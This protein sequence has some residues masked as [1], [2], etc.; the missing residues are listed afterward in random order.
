MEESKERNPKIPPTSLAL[1]ISSLA[2][3]AFDHFS[4]LCFG[5]F[6]RLLALLGLEKRRHVA[7]RANP[8]AIDTAVL[9]TGSGSGIGQFLAIDWFSKGYTIFAV[10]RKVE[11]GQYLEE[12]VSNISH[13]SG[14][15]TGRLIPI[16]IDLADPLSLDSGI[17]EVEENINTLGL[18]LVAVIN[19]AA[20]FMLSVTESL[21]NTEMER[22]MQINLL[23]PIN[24]TKR[25][26]PLLKESKGRVINIGSPNAW[27]PTPGLS[28]Y[29]ITKAALRA[30]SIVFM[31]EAR[32]WEISVSLIEPDSLSNAT[33][34]D[35]KSRECYRPMIQ[36]YQ[37]LVPKGFDFRIHPSHVGR[38]VS[39]ALISPYPKRVYYV[40]WDARIL[41]SVSWLLGDENTCR[42]VEKIIL[43]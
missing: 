4:F 41:A 6:C 35:E 29:S 43:K 33:T 2:L 34:L 8:R 19:N 40:G 20:D 15:P 37:E 23:S 24:L 21:T 42:I 14:K 22:M 11:D 5:I 12:M 39:H 7:I 32:L 17:Q 16:L 13:E 25:L 3:T 10:V 28:V 27:L 18:H 26:Y 9:V 38:A 1:K 30:W 31:I 36:F